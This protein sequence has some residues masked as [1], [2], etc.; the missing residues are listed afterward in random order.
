MNF[1]TIHAGVGKETQLIRDS[2]NVSLGLLMM[3][4]QRADSN[5]YGVGCPLMTQSGHHARSGYAEKG[6]ST[7]KAIEIRT[8]TVA[9]GE[10][11][12]DILKV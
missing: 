11:L 12:F 7:S 1:K 9:R 3:V 4:A 8:P 2:P 5:G 6:G 10:D